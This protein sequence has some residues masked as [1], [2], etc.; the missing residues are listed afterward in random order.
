MINTVI[1]RLKRNL[2]LRVHSRV[3]SSFVPSE[4]AWIRSHYVEVVDEFV[5]FAGLDAAAC[6]G[7]TLL[8]V[9]CGEC[10]TDYGMLRLP[11]KKIV[12]LDI[13]PAEVKSLNTLP[14]RIRSAG[15]TPPTDISRFSHTHYNGI[16]MP[17]DDQAFDIVFSWSAFEHVREVGAVLSEIRRVM[18]NQGVA[19]IQVFPWFPSR[20]GSHLTD[21]LHSPYFHLKAGLPDVRSML[22]GAV[23][24]TP[25]EEDFALGHLWNEFVNL[26]RFSA[27]DFYEQ[28][29]AAGLVAGKV[30]IISY[31]EDLR[32]APSMYKLSDCWRPEL[33]CY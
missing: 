25:Q 7:K 14:D 13:V 16:D 31:C 5:D 24:Q 30:E 12:G 11:F 22:E 28:V 10:I 18:K 27:D 4:R 21:Y 17:F 6:A 3:R 1:R 23:E 32:E 29:K 9:G 26:N 20:Y 8:D 33:K 2:R 15:L 19:F